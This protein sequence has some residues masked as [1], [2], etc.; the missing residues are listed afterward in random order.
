MELRLTV[1]EGDAAINAAVE[2]LQGYEL[3]LAASCS[4]HQDAMLIVLSPTHA[5]RIRS[6]AG[7]EAD[8]QAAIRCM[9]DGVAK[10]LTSFFAV[11]IEL[12][13]AHPIIPLAPPPPSGPLRN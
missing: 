11:P 5:E 1:R 3:A 10:G 12:R 4:K 6:G 8:R 9:L 7:T 13:V 2:M